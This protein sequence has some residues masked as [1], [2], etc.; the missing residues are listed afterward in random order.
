MR[1]AIFT[2]AALALTVTAANADQFAGFYGNTLHIKNADGRMST[3]LVNA[4]GTWSQQMADG[5]SA[6]GTYAWKDDTHFC[7]TVVEPAPKPGEQ[8][9]Q[10]CHEIT[11]NHKPG[12]TWTMTDPNGNAEMSLT[13]GR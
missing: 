13:A 10:E 12:D 4:D 2:A 5:K 6:R 1:L 7:I 8:A 3:V 11:G 9:V